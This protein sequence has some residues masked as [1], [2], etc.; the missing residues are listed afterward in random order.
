MS[1][2]IQCIFCELTTIRLKLGDLKSEFLRAGFARNTKKVVDEI[3]S[4]KASLSAKQYELD[5]T[6]AFWFAIHMEDLE[7]A[8]A[9]MSEEF[10][11]K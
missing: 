5:L 4:S 2:S 7:T 3:R 8:Q 1:A 11:L 9:L 10:L 6:L